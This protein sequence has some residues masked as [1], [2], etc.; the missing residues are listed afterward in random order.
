[1][2][3]L[4][5]FG[6]VLLLTSPCLAWNNACYKSGLPG[7]PFPRENRSIITLE[8]RRVV[9]VQGNLMT[10]DLGGETVVIKTDGV[11]CQSFLKEVQK[12]LCTVKGLISVEP[13]KG[14]FSDTG[15]FKAGAP[16]PR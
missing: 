3:F 4:I 9:G 2:R 15:R 1:M 11:A 13:D 8:A 5:V 7:I 6:A 10:Y 12:G 16:G 14:S